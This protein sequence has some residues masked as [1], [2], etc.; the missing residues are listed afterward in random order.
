VEWKKDPLRKSQHKRDHHFNRN[1][2]ELE[3]LQGNYKVIDGIGEQRLQKAI[4]LI[5]SLYKL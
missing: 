3:L 4:Q 2:E 5:D 1:L